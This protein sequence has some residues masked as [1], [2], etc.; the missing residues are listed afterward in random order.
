M[1]QAVQTPEQQIYLARLM[2]FDYTIQY[3]A[4]KA[5]LAADALSRLP[6]PSRS[7]LYVLTIPN[8]LFLQEL[9]AALAVNQDFVLQ[10]QPLQD[11]PH[12][13][14]GL[15]E[16]LIMYQGRIWL[17]LKFSLIPAILTELHSTP[18]SGH[19]GVMKTLAR[20]RENFVWTSMK[21]DVHHFVTTCFTCQQIKTDNRRSPG[22]LCPLPIPAKPWEDLSLDFIVGLPLYRGHSVILVIVD[23]FSKGLHLGSLPQHHTAAGVA[24]LF[25][26]ISEKLHGMPKSLVSDQDPLFLSHFWHELFKLSGTKLCMSSAYHP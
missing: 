9:R 25:M 10:R 5:N 23:R 12:P 8:C 16:D 20:V 3:R 4:G 17:P 26:E 19:M 6:P 21:K 15:R 7:Q 24:K 14:W 1:A 18:T 13:D 2:G 22:L 11:N